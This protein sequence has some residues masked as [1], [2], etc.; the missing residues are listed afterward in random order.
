MGSETNQSL[1]PGHGHDTLK[2]DSLVS[3]FDFSSQT[4]GLGTVPNNNVQAQVK[5]L[6]HGSLLLLHNS[7][8][9][10]G[11]DPS[12]SDNTLLDSLDSKVISYISNR[13]TRSSI[14]GSS[15]INSY[16]SFE[17]L[18]QCFSPNNIITSK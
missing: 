2:K 6:L 7:P 11:F 4:S 16:V 17:A 5:K 1:S 9:A 10:F 12:A 13:I 15:D 18:G 8:S 3:S 14:G